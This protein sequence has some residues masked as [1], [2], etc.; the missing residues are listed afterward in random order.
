MPERKEIFC[1]G[2]PQRLL[3]HPNKIEWDV[4]ALLDIH[5]RDHR[6]MVAHQFVQVGI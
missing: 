4:E 1:G 2:P 5:Y 6:D 3:V